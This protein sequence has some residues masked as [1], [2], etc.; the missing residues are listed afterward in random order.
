MQSGVWWVM[1]AH[2]RGGRTLRSLNVPTEAPWLPQAW[3]GLGQHRDGSVKG[4]CTSPLPRREPTLGQGHR[5]QWWAEQLRWCLE[6]AGCPGRGSASNPEGT[7]C[8]APSSSRLMPSPLAQ[9]ASRCRAGFCL[10]LRTPSWRQRAWLSQEHFGCTSSEQNPKAL[11]HRAGKV[12]PSQ[13]EHLMA[14]F[15]M[16][17]PSWQVTRYI[18]FLQVFLAA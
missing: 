14:E 8:F 17:V 2:C 4:C 5:R 9:A 16:P 10:W 6:L 11:Q 7:A 12:S 15:F 3:H 1:R 18:R 13:R